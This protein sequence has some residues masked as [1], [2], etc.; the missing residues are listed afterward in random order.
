MSV[1]HC[2]VLFLLWRWR[3]CAFEAGQFAWHNNCDENLIMSS[4]THQTGSNFLWQSSAQRQYL[5]GRIAYCHRWSQQQDGR[6][7]NSPVLKHI[8]AYK[9]L[10][11][12]TWNCIMWILSSITAT[13]WRKRREW[14]TVSENTWY[15]CGVV[16]GCGGARGSGCL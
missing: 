5:S 11:K 16:V 8:I 1:W 2:T 12:K 6:S 7:Y 9:R 3:C 10:K 13:I 14:L 4:L 15:V